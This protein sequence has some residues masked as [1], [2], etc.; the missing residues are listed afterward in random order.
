[1]RFSTIPTITTMKF[2]NSFCSYQRTSPT[3]EEFLLSNDELSHN[4]NVRNQ[5]NN[6]RSQSA[7]KQTETLVKPDKQHIS[8]RWCYINSEDDN[9]DSPKHRVILEAPFV[10]MKE[11]HIN[12]PRRP[13][14]EDSRKFRYYP[15]PQTLVLFFNH[16]LLSLM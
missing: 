10:R 1:V 16:F 7:E 4:N 3:V 5:T 15:L 13:V 2:P 12:P 11:I 14:R 8:R 6:H 9:K